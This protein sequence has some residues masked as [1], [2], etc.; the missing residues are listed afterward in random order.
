M[1]FRKYQHVE[2]LGTSEVDGIEF[3]ECVI[4]PKLDGTNASIWLKDNGELGF[5]S[6]NRELSLE[7]DNAGFMKAMLNDERM[8]KYFKKHPT[9]RLYG[10]WLVPH[11]VKNYDDAAWK[12]FY[13]FDVTV[14]VGEGVEYIPYSVYKPLLEEFNIDYIEPLAIVNNPSKLDFY[15]YLDKNVFLMK[16]GVGEGIVIHNYGFHNQWGRQTWAKIVTSEFKTKHSSNDMFEHKEKAIIEI[17][18]GKIVDEYV[19]EAFVDKEYSKI[20]NE[21]NGWQSKFIPRLLNTVYHC[22][23][24]EEMWNIVKQYKNPKIDFKLLQ[25]LCTQKIK[26]VKSELF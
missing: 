5:G 11:T 13:V 14:D 12:K 6:R 17:I 25:N 9:H 22:L 1:E 7:K 21:E 18:E 19:T 10:E 4:M 16:D 24:T 23:I 15:E 26:T 3:G 8:Y 2:R 20:V